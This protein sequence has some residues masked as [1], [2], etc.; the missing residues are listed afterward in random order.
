APPPSPPAPSPGSGGGSSGSS[1]CS[2]TKWIVVST[3]IAAGVPS[4]SAGSKTYCI[5]AATAA[6]SKPSPCGVTTSTFVTTPSASIEMRTGTSACLPAASAAG[7]YSG[8]T[9]CRSTGALVTTPV[10]AG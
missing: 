1:T 5:A 3:V 8:A 9:A 10:G 4:I 7:G 2:M 6:S